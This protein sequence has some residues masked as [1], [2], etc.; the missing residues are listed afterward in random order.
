MQTE[1]S[2]ASSALATWTEHDGLLCNGD[3][4]RRTNKYVDFL[5]HFE[6]G[7]KIIRGSD[8]IR[9]AFRLNQNS[10]LSMTTRYDFVDYIDLMMCLPL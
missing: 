5:K 7:L 6:N 9:N 10:Y 3:S 2:L 1:H 4:S 8:L